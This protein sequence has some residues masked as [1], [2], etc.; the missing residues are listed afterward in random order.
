MRMLPSQTKN[1]QRANQN[2]TLRRFQSQQ[3]YVETLWTSNYPWQSSR[4]FVTRC[5]PWKKLGVKKKASGN[6][7][8]LAGL[9]KYSLNKMISK[10]PLNKIDD[11]HEFP[12]KRRMVAA[13][14]PRFE[15]LPTSRLK[16]T[17]FAGKP[18]VQTCRFAPFPG[19]SAQTLS[20][21]RTV[22]PDAT[23]CQSCA[24]GTCWPWKDGR[25]FWMGCK[26][27]CGV[28]KCNF[29]NMGYPKS[30]GLWMFIIISPFTLLF[31]AL[32]KFGH[33]SWSISKWLVSGMDSCWLYQINGVEC[34]I[35][36]LDSW[37]EYH[38]T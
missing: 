5:L 12:L 16:K 22:S 10:Y 11:H 18:T 30:R 7:T 24:A 13:N 31:G 23:R 34:Q 26:A 6:Q 33:T 9:S 1:S 3:Q 2:K 32:H 37:G 17:C 36:T 19:S 8:W 25:K 28:V 35:M 38:P 15:D 20:M 14:H 27:T 29:G 4:L 21:K